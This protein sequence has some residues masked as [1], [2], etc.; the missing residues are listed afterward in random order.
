MIYERLEAL[1]KKRGATPATLAKEL[2]L[3]NSITFYWKKGASPSYSNLAKIAEALDTSPQYLNG[4]T[5]N[6]NRLDDKEVLISAIKFLTDDPDALS[7]PDVIAKLNAIECKV[8]EKELSE[9]ESGTAAIPANVMASMKTLVDRKNKVASYQ[10]G[11]DAS[12]SS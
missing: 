3:S 9:Y 1:C 12:Y 6:P 4:L 7:I 10:L 2:N 11:F 8:S 5:D